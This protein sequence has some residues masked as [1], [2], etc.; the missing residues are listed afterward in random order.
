MTGDKKIIYLDNSATTKTHDAVNEKMLDVLHGSWAN[1]S[2]MHSLGIT[3]EK[4]L[5]TAKSALAKTLS[6]NSS[7]IYITSGAT[8]SSNIAINGYLEAVKRRGKHIICSAVEHPAVYETVKHAEKIGYEVDYIS[9]DANG[10]IDLEEFEAKLRADT[11]LTCVMYVNNEVGSIMPIEKLK[12][13]MKKKSPHAALFVDAVQAFG[14]LNIKPSRLGIDM[15]SASAHKIHG[16]KGVG[17]LYLKKD[18]RVEPTVFGGHQQSNLR[19]GTENVFGA[20]GFAVAATLAYESIDKNLAHASALK[21]KLVDGISKID[22]VVINSCDDTLP[23][24]LNVSFVGARAE[25][26]LHA[27]E[28]YGIYVSAGSACSSNAPSPSRTLTAMGKSK[29]E[30]EGALRFSFSADNTEDEI[31]FVIDVLAK[32]VENTRKYTRR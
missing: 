9:V 8:E 1:P 20:A 13:I 22:D 17:L 19:S 5:D 29:A 4:E 32:E 23:Y 24:I 15:L 14:K 12:P 7:E 11:V 26:L 2:S 28:A 30:I 25:V 10:V 16:P 21:A 27:L 6:C 31:D 18:I 3:A